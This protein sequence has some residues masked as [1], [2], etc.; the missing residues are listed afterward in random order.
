MS[1]YLKIV[2]DGLEPGAAE[3]FSDAAGGKTRFP[4][5]ER[6]KRSLVSAFDPPFWVVYLLIAEP[7]DDPS[8]RVL[9]YVGSATA[10]AGQYTGGE[11][12][13]RGHLGNFRNGR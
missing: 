3:I 13:A 4:P 2:V 10:A 7:I 8:G 9:W 6:L 11:S 1:R 12:R 5:L